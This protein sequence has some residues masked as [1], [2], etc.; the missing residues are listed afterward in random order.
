MPCCF[1]LSRLRERGRVRGE[2][3]VIWW[4]NPS[5]IPL[6]NLLIILA[7]YALDIY[8]WVILAAVMASWLVTFGVLNTKN[9]V[10][11]K[12]IYWL[13]RATTPVFSRVR[14]FIPALG[15]IDISPI[16]VILGIYFVRDL[17]VNLA[18]RSGGM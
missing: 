6:M 2:G 15:G 9:R 7:V 1:P 8:L 17:L 14:R 11:Y 3:A 4:A 5:I 12:G 10:V 16:V 13:D 18:F